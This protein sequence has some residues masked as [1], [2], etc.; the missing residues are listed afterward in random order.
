M[1]KERAEYNLKLE[2]QNAAI[3]ALRL[4]ADQDLRNM[5]QVFGLTFAQ[6][7]QTAA[8][9]AS[10]LQFSAVAD[11]ED[12]FLDADS[13]AEEGSSAGRSAA[14]MDSADWCA[15]AV[16]LARAGLFDV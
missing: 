13:M 12:E 7:S 6:H 8:A 1:D 4:Q 9:A 2:A 3:V 11:E 15:L 14:T 5:M 16:I 10:G